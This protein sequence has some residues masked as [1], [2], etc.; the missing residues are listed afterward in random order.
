MLCCHADQLTRFRFCP[1]REG[2]SVA[3]PGDLSFIIGVSG[4]LAGDED[5]WE[6][7]NAVVAHSPVLSARLRAFLAES[8]ELIPAAVTALGDGDLG[9]FGRLAER[10][11]RNARDNL[12]NQVREIIRMQALTHDLG[13]QA[14]SSFGA[15]FGGS[16]WALVPTTDADGFATAW[17][18]R[19]S[20]EF[21]RPRKGP[22]PSSPAPVARPT[23]SE[24]PL[25]RSRLAGLT[26]GL[27]ALFMFAGLTAQANVDKASKPVPRSSGERFIHRPA[28]PCP[29]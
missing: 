1:I 4:I 10:S 19:Y 17:M 5:T 3:L 23:G 22:P 26:D 21:P 9:A 27:L 18:E 29:R 6:G 7:R 20:A 16:V 13:A 2:D 24:P 25:S 11:Q 12:G 14:T 8:E 15:G 28:G